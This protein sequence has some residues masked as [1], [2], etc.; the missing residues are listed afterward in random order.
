MEVVGRHD[1]LRT[2]DAWLEAARSPVLLIE[3]EAG[4]GKTTIWRETVERARESGTRVVSCVPTEAESRLPY[5]GLGDVV[6][7][8]LDDVRSELAR[9]Q[10]RALETALLLR[11]ADEHPADER[12]VDLATLATLRAVEGEVLVAIDDAQWLDRASSGALA[13]A[14][15]RLVVADDVRMLLARRVDIAG[16]L[17]A[18]PESHRLRL[19]PLSLGAIRRIVADRLGASLPRPSLVRVHAASGGNPLYAVELARAEL[20]ADGGLDFARAPTLAELV[21][22][23]L[24]SMPD[25]V[26]EALL[27]VAAASDS[28]PAIVSSA[29]GFDAIETLRP[30]FDLGLV[31][32]EGRRF[33]FTHP[34]LASA[35]H[36]SAPEHVRREAHARLASAPV[37]VEER[38]H[39]LALATIEPHNEVA[40]AVELAGRSARTRGA[41]ADA[42]GLFEQAAELTPPG[43]DAGRGRRL[44]TAADAYFESGDAPRARALLERAAGLQGPSRP[45]A[46]WR[47]AR[48]LDETEGFDP[49]RPEWEEA[50]R[51]DDLAL[52]V[53]VRRSM[54]LAALFVDG[55]RALKEAEAGVAAAERLGEPQP[56]ALAL[57]MEAYV[58][59]VLG[60]SAY[61]EPLDRALALEDVVEPDELHSPSAVLADLG[62]LSLDLDAGRA[63]YVAVLRR[64]EDA[65]NARTETWCVYGLGMVETLAGNLTRAADLAERAT[66]LSYQVTLMGLPAV[67]LSALVAACRGEV[68]R[69]RELIE[70]AGDTARAMGDSVNLLGTLA[71]EGFLELSLGSPASAVD[72]LLEAQSIQAELGLR[73]PGI[74]RFIVDLVEALAATGGVA[75]GERAIAVFTDQAEQ[76]G[77]DWASPLIARAEGLVLAARGDTQAALT[78]LEE[79]VE[80]ELTLPMPLERARTLLA[81]GSVRRQERQRRAA[82]E[83]LRR[84]LA[85]FEELGAPLWAVRAETELGRI[86]GRAPSTGALTPTEQRVAD[87]VAEGKSNKE[88]AA[89]LVVSVHTVEAALT[90]VYRKV[91]VRSRTEMAHELGRSRVSKQ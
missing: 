67:R 11:E 74:T 81:L 37:S 43:D 66:E 27:L 40:L 6:G 48:I 16:G 52:V 83:T 14:M 34:V 45:E 91:G 57:A 62:R 15:R 72:P 31:E 17:E 7:P 39:H 21:Q 50:L 90:S 49:M 78:R 41:P 76:L 19:G 79:A 44:V 35:I 59:G 85:T 63:G 47:L 70:A 84:A 13:F 2:I 8:L 82:R 56:L 88:V 54:A 58:R 18:E 28:S 89:E 33:R 71:I 22:S 24:V 30:A 1:E 23:R 42:A 20:S 53:N 5:T 69:S 25:H 87:L 80:D 51:T 29:L 9:P 60:D 55:T 36:A 68:E 77:R 10:L 32:I 26:R 75:E 61:R 65:G 86:G 38:G 4:I 3:G 46:M 73:E 64:A 12:A